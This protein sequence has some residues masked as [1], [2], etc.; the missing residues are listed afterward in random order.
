[1]KLKKEIFY[2]GQEKIQIRYALN[3]YLYEKKI[4]PKMR[5]RGK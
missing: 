3:V 5:P 1:M 4:A 2:F